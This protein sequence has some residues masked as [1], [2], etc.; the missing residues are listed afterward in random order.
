MKA[1][2]ERG[3]AEEEALE[4]KGADGSPHSI[5]SKNKNRTETKGK[6]SIIKNY[7]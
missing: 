6:I 4:G 3:R 5:Q 7:Y 2:C 1:F